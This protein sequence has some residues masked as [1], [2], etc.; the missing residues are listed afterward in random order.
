M[1]QVTLSF[2]KP[3]LMT[4]C[5]I[6][7]TL[8][9][10]FLFLI[11][12]SSSSCLRYAPED[13][14]DQVGSFIEVKPDSALILLESI[15]SP[16]SLSQEDYARY[17]LLL[18]KAHKLNRISITDDAFITYII[19]Y[20]EKHP[21]DDLGRAYFYAGQ[22][23]EEQGK[24]T[25]AEHYYLKAFNFEGINTHK[26]KAYSAYF[27]ADIYDNNLK[28]YKKAIDY[29]QKGL[30]YFRQNNLFFSEENILKLI[31]DCYVKDQQFDKGVEMYRKS[32]AK[33]PDDSISSKAK[34]Y[35]DIAVTL[36]G[37]KK[38]PEAKYAINKAIDIS[39]RN[40][41]LAIG[42]AIKGDIFEKEGE[43][44]SILYY[45]NR[46]ISFAKKSKDYQTMH[47]AYS[48]IYEIATK[49]NNLQLALDNYKSFNQVT[50]IIGQKQKY[51]DI[52]YLERKIDFEKNRNLYLK[53]RLKVQTIIF[54]AVL[55]AVIIPIAFIYYRYRKKKHIEVISQQLHDKKEIIRSVMEARSQNIEIYRR[56]VTLSISPQKN[57][58]RHFLES[59]NKILF[60]QDYL[61]EFDWEYLSAL[62][63][64]N[65]N[66]YVDRLIQTYPEMTDM[67]IKIGILLKCG[68]SLTEIAEITGK[69]S[70][71][72]YK[73]SSHIRKKAGI[74]E[75]K[76]TVEFL[77]SVLAM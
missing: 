57:K 46:A 15:E 25:E 40:K 32:I 22:V 54:L 38:Y 34:I 19:D 72:I 77:D 31:G 39:V 53:N 58:Y 8:S 51:D 18:I 44:D 66:A 73:Y 59:A 17:G 2:I 1:L 47:N 26:L 7:S 21:C 76:N 42:Y 50:E 74:P 65:Y 37:L 63:N 69:S 70:H 62:V 23:F 30:D 41:D 75:N 13:I 35:R 56:M 33:I 71:T 52:K 14:L 61:F 9:I 3:K 28:E 12:F 68:F 43:G 64:E 20:Y 6:K 24:Y 55:V 16:E 48:S 4:Y 10:L 60:G 45:N 5:Y 67:E 36:I 27:L 11:I 49:S 29:Y